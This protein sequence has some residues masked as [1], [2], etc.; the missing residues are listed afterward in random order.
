MNDNE[1]NDQFQ[2]PLTFPA[3]AVI[4]LTVTFASARLAALMPF[5]PAATDI[6][7]GSSDVSNR[8]GDECLWSEDVLSASV[9]FPPQTCRSYFP[10]TCCDYLS[11]Q[12]AAFVI[13]ASCTVLILAS[14]FPTTQFVR[15][16]CRLCTN[17]FALPV[18]GERGVADRVN[19]SQHAVVSP[20]HFIFFAH[21]SLVDVAAVRLFSPEASLTNRPVCFF[22]SYWRT[23]PT[24]SCCFAS[25]QGSP[26]SPASPRCWI[27]SCV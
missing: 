16:V 14:Y 5:L 25:A 13:N 19:S 9:T 22:C 8:G 10:C 1:N 24:S 17:V 6:S 23:E 27:R 21:V 11:I 18:P 12:Y 15:Y 26:F 2:T 3:A 7:I 20:L 4:S